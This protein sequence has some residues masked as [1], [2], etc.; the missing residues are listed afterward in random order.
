MT[1]K[2]YASNDLGR[3]PIMPKP[4]SLYLMATSGAGQGLAGTPGKD[5]H[6]Q[7]GTAEVI[8]ETEYKVDPNNPEKDIAVVTTRTKVSMQILETSGKYTVL[9]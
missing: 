3:P 1:Q 4:D 8:E 2:I 5:L 6:L 9:E 7:R